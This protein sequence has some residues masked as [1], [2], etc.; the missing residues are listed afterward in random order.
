MNPVQLP[1]NP[2]VA[3]LT[4]NPDDDRKLGLEYQLRR[5]PWATPGAEAQG[6]ID[7][8]AHANAALSKTDPV[9]ALVCALTKKITAEQLYGVEVINT[10]GQYFIRPNILVNS[11]SNLCEA[12]VV[13]CLA[14]GERLPGRKSLRVGLP[15]NSSPTPALKWNFLRAM[16]VRQIYTNSGASATA[17]MTI[18]GTWAAGQVYTV[19]VRFVSP[20][21][22]TTENTSTATLSYTTVVGDANNA[23]AAASFV[24]AWN[25]NPTLA[26]LAV[27]SVSSGSTVLLT[28][29]N[30]GSLIQQTV[31]QTS[32]TGTGTFVVNNQFTGAVNPEVA[33]AFE[34]SLL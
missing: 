31:L 7:G 12:N 13:L 10:V 5:H 21:N 19:G 25:A 30:P 18:G 6:I 17:S 3:Q 33:V 24:T 4:G 32:A 14:E 2:T 1:D 8:G 15:V 28:A 9:L 26:A 16:V 34:S 29:V 20:T 23:G 11:I 22:P 27:A